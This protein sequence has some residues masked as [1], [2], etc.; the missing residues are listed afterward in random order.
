MEVLVSGRV[1]GGHLYLDVSRHT[2]YCCAPKVG[3]RSGPLGSPDPTE[4]PGWE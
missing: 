2:G 1:E 3:Q 4:A